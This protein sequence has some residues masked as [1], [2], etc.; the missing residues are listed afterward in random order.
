MSVGPNSIPRENTQA[1]L[2]SALHAHA[3][4]HYGRR[5]RRALQRN[6]SLIKAMLPVASAAVD[7]AVYG[8]DHIYSGQPAAYN[9]VRPHLTSL[10]DAYASIPAT[11]TGRVMAD[12]KATRDA[13]DL[14]E[15][16]IYALL[17][18]A[19]PY[20]GLGLIGR[21]LAPIAIRLVARAIAGWLA[22]LMT[23]GRLDAGADEGV[24]MVAEYGRAA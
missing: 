20:M 11:S 14:I 12:I 4:A 24:R 23:E 2:L 9:S 21:L 6:E 13:R 8:D 10:R 5:D 1:A 19:V 22:D 15:A 7:D 18:A 3:H 17:M 16:A